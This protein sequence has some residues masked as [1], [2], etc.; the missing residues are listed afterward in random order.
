MSKIRFHHVLLSLL[1]LS[2]ISII[3]IPRYPSAQKSLDKV[4]APVR[5]LFVPVSQPV[6]VLSGWVHDRLN[7]PRPKNESTQLDLE[8]QVQSL[9]NE[10]SNLTAQLEKLKQIVEDRKPLGNLRKL[11]TPAF[12]AG[13]DGSNDEVLLL[14]QVEDV[15]REMNNLAVVY[16]GGIVGRAD[17]VGPGLGSTVLL[18]TNKRSRVTGSFGRFVQ[19]GQDQ[20]QYVS[21]PMPAALVEGAGNGKMLIRGLTLR[22]VKES[23]IEENDWVV[24]NDN[25]WPEVV[26]GLKIGKVT[27]IGMRP[28]APQFA[29][30]EVQPMSNLR[31]LR[32]VMVLTKG[33]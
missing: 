2:V 7:P 17:R 9:Q 13:G 21:L 25:K 4:R 22:D 6:H 11:C 26:Q 12:V 24:L 27:A 30:I 19:A 23:G 33:Q 8:N 28:D 16:S 5:Y 20:V 29:Q 14:N 18:L 1:T 32:E 15:S 10:V 3:F 31:M